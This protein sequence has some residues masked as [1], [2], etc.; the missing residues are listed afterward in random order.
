M[1]KLGALKK[2]DAEKIVAQVWTDLSK[3]TVDAFVKGANGST[4]TLVKLMGRVHQLMGINRLEKPDT[5]I[6]AAAGELLM[7]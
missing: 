7:R 4:R 2:A 3:E 6:I 1:V 5:E